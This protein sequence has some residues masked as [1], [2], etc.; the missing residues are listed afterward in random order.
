MRPRTRAE[1]QSPCHRS[2]AL[3]IDFSVVC[4]ARSW[5]PH[6]PIPRRYLSPSR[7]VIVAELAA[8][9]KHARANR[10]SSVSQ[11]RPGPL[12]GYRLRSAAYVSKIDSSNWPFAA[13]PFRLAPPLP[14]FLLPRGD[15]RLVSCADR[16]A[17]SM[18]SD[19]STTR[20]VNRSAALSVD[21]G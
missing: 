5:S 11:A 12:F 15:C 7:P 13:G 3:R 19:R 20:V 21:A 9:S 8:S 10:L 17:A 4:L 14:C 6:G 2:K 18:R 16:S 1:P